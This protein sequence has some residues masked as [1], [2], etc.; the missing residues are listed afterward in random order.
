MS[1]RIS[2]RQRKFAATIRVLHM[3]NETPQQVAE[4]LLGEFF[5]RRD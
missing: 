2:K 1:N 5:K 3:Q 4:R